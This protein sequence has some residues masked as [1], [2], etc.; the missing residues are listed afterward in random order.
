M[1]TLSTIK[2]T[3]L[4]LAVLIGSIL[5]NEAGQPVKGDVDLSS[6]FCESRPGHFH[7]GIDIRTGGKIGRKVYSPINGYVWRIKYSFIGYGKGLYLKDNQDVI[8][9]FG[10]LSRLSD[11]LERIVKEYQYGNKA[12]SL[13]NFYEPDSIPV[14]RG[15]LL[16]IS[17]QSGYGAPHI[18]YEIRTPSNKPLNPLT[19]G[20]ELEDNYAPE[21][22]GIGL[23]SHDSALILPNGSRREYYRAVFDKRQGL[24]TTDTPIPIRGPF[25]I[26]V[27]M[28]DRIRKNGPRLN[29]HRARMY[30]DDYLYYETI[31]NTYDYEE[32]RTVDLCFDYPLT[33]NDNKDWHLLYIPEGKNYEG[34]KSLYTDG[35]VY[36]KTISDNYG[37]HKVRVEIADAADNGSE[38]NFDF[39]FLPRENLFEFVS[40]SDSVLFLEMNRESRFLDIKKIVVYSRGKK[41]KWQNLGP[42]RVESKIHGDYR[43]TIPAGRKKPSALKLEVIGESGWRFVDQ[44]LILSGAKSPIYSFDYELLDGGILFNISSGKTTAVSPRIEIVY[45][46][47]YTK[48]ISTRAIKSNTFAAFYKNDQIQSDITFFNLF[49]GKEDILLISI[50]VNIY[51]C[52]LDPEVDYSRNFDDL[53]VEYSRADFFSPS[54]IEIVNP[55]GTFPNRKSVYSGV[56]E[57]GPQTVPLAGDIA[58]SMILDGKNP[59]KLGFYRLTGKREWFWLDHELDDG[60]IVS[61]SRLL[62]TFAFLKDTKSPRIKKIYPPNGKTVFTGEPDIY[63]TVTDDL[64][65]ISD[66]KQTVIKLDGRWLI[67]EYDPETKILQTTPDRYL[68]DGKHLLEISVTDRSGN[69]RTVSS[70]FYVNTKRK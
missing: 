40:V 26:M 19:Y 61:S 7:G 11:R 44:V 29:I 36:G 39:V 32:T 46:D 69:N 52:G 22:T 43:L 41:G 5:A 23:I 12:Y 42:E 58:I 49:G 65:G 16:G 45:S 33:I 54:Y 35:G 51:H 66:D 37:L 3:L 62:G 10:H 24:Y 70:S 47:G 34:S 17:G 1:N 9:V 27:K 20:F 50:P 8:Y 13:D 38:L 59:D 21:I 48:T 63:C 68:K 31:Y 28:Y 60:R 4:M 30:I 2:A 25:G 53:Q 64:S 67:P 14:S 56:Y 18:H 55:T 15:E 6:N 57:I